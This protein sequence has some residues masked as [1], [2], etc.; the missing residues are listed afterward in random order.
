[1]VIA[2]GNI[3]RER[4]FNRIGQE[5]GGEF[6]PGGSKLE[7]DYYQPVVDDLP[8][9]DEEPP[10]GKH[11]RKYLLR[12]QCARPPRSVFKKCRRVIL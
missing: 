7:G 1:M 8:G 2:R 4:T 9:H 3:G 11:F 10:H 5:C 6:E 12:R